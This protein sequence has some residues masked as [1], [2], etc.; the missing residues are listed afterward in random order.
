MSASVSIAQPR[1][2]A[3]QPLPLIHALETHSFPR[4]KRTVAIFNPSTAGRFIGTETYFALK[5]SAFE[6]VDADGDATLTNGYEYAVWVF[7]WTFAATTSTMVSGAVAERIDF[8][9]YIVYSIVLTS[10]IYPVVVHWAWAGG[11][12]SAF[13][14]EDDLLFGC[15][16][17][18]FAG[19][20]VVH[21]LG[22]LAAL[23]A[24][25]VVGPRTGRFNADGTAN[26]LPQQSALLQ[27]WSVGCLRL[28]FVFGRGVSGKV[29]SEISFLC[30]AAAEQRLLLLCVWA[31]SS[32]LH[33]LPE[34]L[35]FIYFTGRFVSTTGHFGIR[36]Q[37]VIV[38][39]LCW[40]AVRQ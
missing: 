28:L 35:T 38:R 12:A 32:M 11:W 25:I 33:V 19:S 27:V 22:G 29:G 9:A 24:C 21:G 7:Q 17:L 15:G 40:A 26:S 2:K 1:T 16:L 31:S 34:N 8:N 13:V 23:C 10:F 14:E 6:V 37:A 3:I 4:P 5:G 18:D 30:V 36:N 20:G 39:V